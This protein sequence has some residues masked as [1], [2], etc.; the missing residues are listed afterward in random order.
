MGVPHVSPLGTIRFEIERRIR[1]ALGMSEFLVYP[2]GPRGGS[3]LLRIGGR[4]QLFEHGK[5]HASPLHTFLRAQVQKTVPRLTKFLK[6]I[7]VSE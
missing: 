3:I 7:R 1:S 2:T 6:K 4:M 5:N